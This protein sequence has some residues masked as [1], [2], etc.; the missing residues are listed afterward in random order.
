MKSNLYVCF[1][2]ESMAYL[3][4]GVSRL[5][6]S[7]G[8]PVRKEGSKIPQSKQYIGATVTAQRTDVNTP[9][10]HELSRYIVSCVHVF[11]PGLA[12]F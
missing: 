8:A 11:H 3:Q 9:R 7:R 6:H 10:A 5:A 2:R 12:M 4:E 1:P